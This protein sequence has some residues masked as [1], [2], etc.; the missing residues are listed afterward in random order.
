MDCDDC[1]NYKPKKISNKELETLFQAFDEYCTGVDCGVCPLES[2]SVNCLVMKARNKVR[3]V[4][5]GE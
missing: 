2:I 1:K 5:Y 3:V 4:L